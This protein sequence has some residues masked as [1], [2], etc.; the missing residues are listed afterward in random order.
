MR[1]QKKRYAHLLPV[2]MVVLGNIVY[3]CA[4]K[5][6]LLP[7]NL[8]SS[9]TTGIA[10]AVNHAT[11]LPVTTFILVFNVVM[12]GVGWLLLGGKFALTTVGSSLMYP[13]FLEVLNRLLGDV[14][15]TDNTLLNVLF[16]GMLLGV[17]LGTVVRAGASTGGMDIPLLAMQKYFRIP[18]SI[19][20]Y[21]A[22]FC[23]LMLQTSYHTAEDLLYGVLL[24]LVTSLMLD[25]MMLLG[26]TKTEVKIISEK[27]DAIRVEILAGIDRGVT[28]L[29]AKGGYS[30]KESQVV[31][32]V[33]SNRELVKV[34]KAVR[35]IDPESFIIVSRVSEVWGRGFSR[36]KHYHGEKS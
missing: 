21:V 35:S 2:V 27:S 30:G 33:V 10:L 24:L 15:L 12:L 9:G 7:A 5:L 11:G 28:L 19:S 22:D 1:K 14:K 32:T 26:V 4:V 25:K 17:A 31:L 23:I 8:M 6:F 34:E 16:S 20:L 29:N 36:E 13:V 3:A 18:L